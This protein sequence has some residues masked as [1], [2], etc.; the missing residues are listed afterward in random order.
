MIKNK[1]SEKNR[2]R[3]KGK[4]VNG[5]KDPDWYGYL[6]RKPDRKGVAI[7]LIVVNGRVR[8]H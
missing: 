2:N 7:P 1:T 4:P 5:K 8:P 6:D 3:A